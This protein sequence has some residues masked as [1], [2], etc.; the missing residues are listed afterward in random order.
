MGPTYN[1]GSL[2][3]AKDLVVVITGG[4]SGLGRMMAHAMAANGAKAVYVL[5]R[6]QEPLD[7]TKASSTNPDVVHT[8]ICD[9]ISKDSLA[10]AAAQVTEEVGYI[11]VLFANSGVMSGTTEMNDIDGM[12]IEELQERL[13]GPDM[14]D[15]NNAY[16]VNVTG[17]YYTTVAFLTLLSR[18]N[19]RGNVSQRSQ[20]I[21]TSSIGGYIRKPLSGFAYGASK[22]AVNL[23]FKQLSTV[24][25]NWTIR[26]NALAP[27]FYP[28]DMTS[29]MPFMSERGDPRVEGGM[30]KEMVPLMRCGAEE[31]LAGAVLFL[32][33][34]AG[35]YIDGNQLVTDGGRLA[36]VQGTY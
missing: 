8:I 34:P 1:A 27:G 31:D 4:G 16:H 33:S 2:F 17:A 26:V 22:A 12:S 36:L 29:G 32:V 35:A 9:V 15:F 23:L 7:E 20:V 5:G 18:G 28:S 3:H 10:A 30:T 19:E 24:L 6:R 21:V 14:D 11:N 25:S 13:W